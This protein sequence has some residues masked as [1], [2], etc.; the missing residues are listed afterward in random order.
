MNSEPRILTAS[1][2]LLTLLSL[3]FITP[4]TAHASQ[5]TSILAEKIDSAELKSGDRILLVTRNGKTLSKNLSG[6]RV[7]QTGVTLAETPKRSVITAFPEDAAVFEA[8]FSE[9]EDLTLTCDAGCLTSAETGNGLFYAAEPEACS[10][11]ELQDGTFLYNK[12]ASYTTAAGKTYTNYYLESYSNYF[13]TYGKNASSKPDPFTFDIYRLG[14]SDPDDVIPE[15]NHYYLPVFETS[16]IHGWLADASGSEPL[17]LLACISDKVKD[18][19]GYSDASRKDLAVLLD[20]GDIYQGNTM[21]NLLYGQPIAAAFEIMGYDAVTIGNHEFDWGIE[22]VIDPDKT[23]MDCTVGDSSYVNSVPVVISNMYK[24]GEKAALG[25]DYII[26]EKTAVNENGEELPVRIGVIGYAGEY[27]GDIMYSMFTGA[28]YTIDTDLAGVNAIASSLEESGLCDATILLAHAD[29]EYVAEDLGEGSAIDLVLG[30]H[31][32][33]SKNGKSSHGIPYLEPAGYAAA[34]CYARLAF[35]LRDGTPVFKKVAET[36]VIGTKD[37]TSRLTDTP[38]NA[39][40]LDPELVKLTDEVLAE[41][42]EL[43]KSEVGYITE[44]ALKSALPESGGRSSTCG[45]WMAS[46]LARIVGADVGFVNG[47]GIRTEIP[48]PENENRRTITLSDIYTLFPFGNKVYCYEITWEDFLTLLTYSLTDTGKTLL[49]N[50]SGADVYFT[51]ETV[52]AILTADGKEV[53]AGGEWKGDYKDRTLRI[54][55]SEFIA[56]TDRISS[57]GM[58][59]PLV[60]WNAGPRLIENVQIDNEGAITVLVD[61]AAANEGHLFIDTNPHY[62]EKVYVPKEEDSVPAEPEVTPSPTVTPAPEPAV[63]PEPT[64][65]PVPAKRDENA[66]PSIYVSPATGEEHSDFILLFL[67]G[68]LCTVFFAGAFRREKHS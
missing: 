62:C 37:D 14:N 66:D 50:L 68:A 25:D 27:S 46:I 12:N 54:A 3:L 20:T 6:T 61:E 56:T 13:T 36:N 63:S 35:D 28:G 18:V 51:D 24:N 33:I 29:G 7:V 53:Y 44:S 30:G 45:N 48:V 4:L 9:N 23:I 1:K 52:T 39:D 49:T 8:A 16:D 31:S 11:W 5:N 19:R 17:Y 38:E 21:S 26:L 59:N 47:G 2:L 60:A 64:V 15:E 42:D 22:N 10:L 40:E 55:A 67:T 41:L 65:T 58:S 34:Y 43:F 32:H 57:G